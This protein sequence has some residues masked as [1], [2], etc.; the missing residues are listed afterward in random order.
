MIETFPEIVQNTAEWFDIR[1]GLATA[2]RFSDILAKG[3]GLSRAKYMRQLAGE[4][5]TGRPMNTVKTWAMDRGHVEEERAR[6]EYAFLF[7]TRLQRVGFVRNGRKGCSPDGLVDGE[8]GM[9]EFK[10]GEPDIHIEVIERSIAEPDF[11]PTE[12]KAQTQ[13][14]LWVCERE[15]IDI[16]YPSQG[17]IPAFRK[18]IVRDPKFIAE[19]SRAVDEFNAELDELV[20]RIKSYV[21]EGF[22]SL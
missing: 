2:S 1:K 18:R 10:S 6:A 19:L 21:T 13:G 9:A 11:Y 8:P 14:N 20:A 4:I 5:I 16:F 15:W 22:S 12:H 17:D 3:K 7:N